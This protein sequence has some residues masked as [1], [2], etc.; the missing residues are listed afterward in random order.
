MHCQNSTFLRWLLFAI[1]KAKNTTTVQGIATHRSRFFSYSSRNYW[2][3]NYGDH[4]IRGPKRQIT[5]YNYSLLSSIHIS[6]HFSKRIVHM[7]QFSMRRIEA[8]THLQCNDN[9]Y[10]MKALLLALNILASLVATAS[11]QRMNLMISRTALV[12][13]WDLSLYPCIHVHIYGIHILLKTG[14]II[15]KTASY[16]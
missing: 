16:C 11:V 14:D 3:V 2:R 7:I 4:F 8:S 9:E 12:G 1:K 13:I 5:F 15:R 6:I 10:R